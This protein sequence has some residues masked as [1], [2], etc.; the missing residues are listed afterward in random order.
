MASLTVNSTI[1]WA[2][3]NLARICVV[4]CGL[5]GIWAGAVCLMSSPM[6]WMY[7]P[8]AVV[9]F[10]GASFRISLRIHNEDSGI[11]AGASHA[12][13]LACALAFGP[14]GGVLPAVFSCLGLLAT[15]PGEDPVQRAL[16]ITA[17]PAAASAAGFIFIHAGGSPLA[18]S[19]GW[20][21]V[22]A[23]AAFM[24][25]AVI[26]RTAAVCAAFA[27]S[28]NPEP[29]L[30]TA[31]RYM[32][33]ASAA[34]P[35][36]AMLVSFPIQAITALAFVAAVGTILALRKKKLQTIP[37]EILAEPVKPEH[38]EQ[39]ATEPKSKPSVLDPLTGAANLRYLLMF[40]EQ[41]I[42][43]SIRNSHAMSLLLLDVDGLRE[44]NKSRGK[45]AGDNVLKQIALTLKDMLRDYDVVARY[46]ED[47]FAVVL[48]ETSPDNA[49]DIAERIHKTLV[50]HEYVDQAEESFKV[51]LSVGI[52]SFPEHGEGA[53]E[54]IS[55]AH[56][57][58]N[59]AK[60]AKNSR[61]CSCHKLAKAG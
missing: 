25:Y 60:F 18:L 30:R 39:A 12:L 26:Y 8:I 5:A 17:R 52:A 29:G 44:I 6:N 49:L 20:P 31:T 38:I 37:E 11:D 7:V 56:H 59:R 42:S 19:S 24:A 9:A 28:R 22:P 32:L 51:S 53:D 48:P 47:E 10:F 57:A 16:D 36:S 61:V 1:M 3:Q 58:L 23:L 35:L 4:A 33:S 14:L 46:S 34:Y 15:S 43:R 50:S 41:E 55:S 40:L 2:G 27:Y 21:V 45:Q 54:L 13:I